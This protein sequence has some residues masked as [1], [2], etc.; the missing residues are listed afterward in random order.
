MAAMSKLDAVIDR[1]KALPEEE[2][3]RLAWKIEGLLEEPAQEALGLTDAEWAE[4]ERRRADP[5]ETLIDQAEAVAA[6]R[7]DRS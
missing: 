1:L 7:L 3:V 4:I 5:Q 6:F 2:Q